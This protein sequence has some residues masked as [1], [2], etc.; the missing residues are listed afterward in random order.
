MKREKKPHSFTQT[1]PCPVPDYGRTHLLGCG[2]TRPCGV[3]RLRPAA[4]LDDQ[5]LAALGYAAR[6]IKEFTPGAQALDG[7]SW[8]T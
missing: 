6:D 1:A 7:E 8:L 2:K 4:D 5:Q 3:S